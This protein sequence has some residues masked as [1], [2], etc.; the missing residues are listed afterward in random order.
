M[1]HII[2]ITVF[3]QVIICAEIRSQSTVKN[4]IKDQIEKMLVLGG[5]IHS[6]DDVRGNTRKEKKNNK[7]K[8]KILNTYSKDHTIIPYLTKSI[9]IHSYDK[10][11][12]LIS[13]YILDNDEIDKPFSFSGE[14]DLHFLI[15]QTQFEI[16]KPDRSSNYYFLRANS[17]YMMSLEGGMSAGL[18]AKFFSSRAEAAM[19]SNSKSN[20]TLYVGVG[21]F[22]NRIAEIF[23]K[24]NTGSS[25]NVKDA[26]EFTPLLDIWNL[27][28][29]DDVHK[30]YW[31]LSNFLGILTVLRSERANKFGKN[32]DFTANSGITIPFLKVN[33]S[34][35][36]EWK[37]SRDFFSQGGKFHT[38]LL[39]E[40]NLEEIP[41]AKD[42]E[43]VWRDFGDLR[44]YYPNDAD[45]IIINSSSNKSIDLEFGPL[46]ESQIGLIEIDKEYTIE[47]IENRGGTLGY[48]NNEGN[49][50][51]NIRI[52]EVRKSETKDNFW[53]VPITL[54]SNP[55]FFEQETPTIQ[56]V[57]FGVK[58]RIRNGVKIN[59]VEKFL[60]R[61]YTINSTL[62]FDPL[63]ES[64]KEVKGIIDE[65]SL[66][67]D[68][69]I[70]VKSKTTWEKPYITGI[71]I[72]DANEF[73]EQILN[74]LIK[75]QSY[76]PLKEAKFRFRLEADIPAD[77]EGFMED[78]VLTIKIEKV[79]KFGTKF[80]RVRTRLDAPP[81]K[82]DDEDK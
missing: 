1:K 30:D 78:A 48:K 16:D 2:Y 82:K 65:K 31:I 68:I 50:L 62:E 43:I 20:S 79:D 36:S 33:A 56:E 29:R 54:I 15:N 46:N 28:S 34:L 7:L 81:L 6:E 10:D 74:E 71:Q 73:M 27:R 40:I 22:S 47:D 41:S 58:L 52:G 57:K 19:A 63:I 60:S 53:I 75:N 72:K 5:A 44:T 4:L 35:E 59:K 45:H 76:T 9:G 24:V 21:R 8:N 13:S 37:K 23:K 14:P 80:R 12:K 3:C 70:E 64:K 32:L 39:D 18:D 42:I 38:V 69:D 51:Q 49:F 61:T 25:I 77:F 11:I 67:F 26:N 17:T 55:K 66:S